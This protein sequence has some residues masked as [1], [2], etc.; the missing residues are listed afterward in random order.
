M[1]KELPFAEQF[2]SSCVPKNAT[3]DEEDLSVW[4][5]KLDKSFGGGL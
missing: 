1:A 4:K 3:I 5:M 2:W